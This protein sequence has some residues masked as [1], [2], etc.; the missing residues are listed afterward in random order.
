MSR[1]ILM[2]VIGIALLM[3]DLHAQ[4]NS[5]TTGYEGRNPYQIPDRQRNIY[6]NQS[7]ENNSQK[8]S[9]FSSDV[10]VTEAP[11]GFDPEVPS[12]PVDGGLGLLLAAGLGYGV[13]R[14]RRRGKANVL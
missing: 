3:T 12:T 13:R 1:R 2:I 9:F 11:P 8:R 6:G 7:T 5:G 10:T 4:Y 14:L